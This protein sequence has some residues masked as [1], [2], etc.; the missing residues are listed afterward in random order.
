[1]AFALVLSLFFPLVAAE[2]N[3]IK[4]AVTDPRLS[5]LTSFIGGVNLKVVSLS[6]WNSDGKL[7]RLKIAPDDMPEFSLALDKADA[8]GYGLSWESDKVAILYGDCPVKNKIDGILADPA[9]LP[10]IGQRILVAI[11][12]IDP[13]GYEYYQRRL[14]EFQSRLDST[15]SMGRKVLK[16]AR[17][18]DVAGSHR[19]LFLAAGCIVESADEATVS[20]ISNILSSKGK[21]RDRALSELV[22]E[23]K[24][25]YDV[26]LLDHL[27]SSDTIE[28]GGKFPFVIVIPP[29]ESTQDPVTVL[30]DRYLAVWNVIRNGKS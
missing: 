3:G 6:S 10:F 8:V 20:R 17:I 1:M 18:L 5:S 29:L 9:T 30:Y 13:K 23:L 15:V 24:T 25:R 21:E 22:E 14:A 16:G 4:L 2:A 27:S 19:E 28:I 7:V 26:V 11:S 12:D